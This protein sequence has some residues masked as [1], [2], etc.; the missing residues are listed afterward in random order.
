MADTV[1]VRKIAWEIL[2]P[3]PGLH[4]RWGRMLTPSREND[5]MIFGLGE[6][7]PGEESGWHE[8]P[9]PEIF[10]LLEG[11]GEAQWRQDGAEHC[12]PLLPGVAFFKVGGVPHQMRNLGSVP[13][14]GVAFKIGK[15]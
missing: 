8:H 9:E 3:F 11:T 5:G 2:R 14:R 13:F 15:A 10:F 1:W 7:Q 12:A 4:G 6:L